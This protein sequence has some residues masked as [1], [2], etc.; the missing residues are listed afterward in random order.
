MREEEGRNGGNGVGKGTGR[1][2][3]YHSRQKRNVICSRAFFCCS[4][5]E[6]AGEADIVGMGEGAVAEAVRILIGV[7]V[8][9][10]LGARWGCRSLSWRKVEGM[11]MRLCSWIEGER[12][13]GELSPIRIQLRPHLENRKVPHSAFNSNGRQHLCLDSAASLTPHPLF[14]HYIPPTFADHPTLDSI[15]PQ[16]QAPHS[17]PTH[18]TPRILSSPLSPPSPPPTNPAEP[19][20]SPTPAYPQPGKS[21]TRTPK[22]SPTTSTRRRKNRAGSRPPAPTPTSSKPTWRSTTAA[23]PARSPFPPTPTP[24]PATRARS[25]PPISSSSTATAGARAAGVRPS[26]RG[27]ARRRSGF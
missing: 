8:R 19:P 23:C 2:G 24:A 17:P 4:P 20:P 6:G 14:P 27:A 15:P 1:R 11:I 12:K 7:D 13:D 16:W 25:A 5:S 22:T 9:W 26:S 10:D 21:D 18:P 3:T